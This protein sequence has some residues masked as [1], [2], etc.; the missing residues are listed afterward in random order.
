MKIAICL[1]ILDFITGTAAAMKHRE[2]RSSR[3]RDGLF[4]KAGFVVLYILG[5]MWEKWGHE[6]GLPMGAAVLTGICVYVS[7]IEVISL[8]E[9]L[10]RLNPDIVPGK[11]ISILQGVNKNGE[12]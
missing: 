8:L 2:I 12:G 9:N 6:I 10:H 4:K 5:W 3:M 11:I 1:N 7:A